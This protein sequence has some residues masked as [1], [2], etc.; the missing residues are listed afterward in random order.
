M[1]VFMS[2]D[3]F[4][5]KFLNMAALV[6]DPYFLKMRGRIPLKNVCDTESMTLYV[7]DCRGDMDQKPQASEP[8]KSSPLTKI[9]VERESRMSMSIMLLTQFRAV[10]VLE[11][12]P[13]VGP[14]TPSWIQS[15]NS[16]PMAGIG[17][18]K[19][20]NSLPVW[21]VA[22]ASIVSP[23]H[24]H[25]VEVDGTQYQDVSSVG[26]IDLCAA[27][28]A[29][30]CEDPGCEQKPIA[31]SIGSKNP[32][33]SNAKGSNAKY[34]ETHV[35]AGFALDLHVAMSQW[36]YEDPHRYYR[37]KISKN[38]HH[39]SSRSIRKIKALRPRIE[40]RISTSNKYISNLLR[41]SSSRK[42]MATSTDESNRVASSIYT[43]TKDDLGGSAI[44]DRNLR[45]ITKFTE[46]Y[47]LRDDVQ[48][49][50]SE[51]AQTLVERRRYCA[52][53]D[54]AQ[55]ERKGYRVCYRCVFGDCVEDDVAYEDPD[56]LSLH[57]QQRHPHLALS[58]DDFI[59][60]LKSCMIVVL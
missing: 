52:R 45:S 24:R 23:S 48:R 60:T 22:L 29:D 56:T 20:R 34:C 8:V 14:P 27:I 42:P 10:L 31:V 49:R 54:P 59:S 12:Q 58:A 13:S 32:E 57:L 25:P 30:V 16:P 6:C 15:Y 53:L 21:Q 55:S 46:A 33:R 41:T 44:G 26:Y 11:W 39:R 19:I 50:M 18:R 17:F 37:F 1:I 43:L 40:R 7:G 51:C 47:L 38:V 4:V 5:Q 28:Y 35:L 3:A 2:T 36:L 9:D